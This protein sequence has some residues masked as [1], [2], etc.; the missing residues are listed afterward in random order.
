MKDFFKGKF[1]TGLIV[2]ATVILAGVAI[3]TAVR[4]YQLRR[5]NISLTGPESEPAAWD[6]KKYSFSVSGNGLVTVANNSGKNEAAQQAQVYI[7]DSLAATFDVPALPPGQGATLG[8]VQIPQ[9]PTF[10]WRVHGTK[11]C[12][13]SGETGSKPVACT[14]LKFNLAT[15]TT[16][17]SPTP[18][19]QPSP[20]PTQPPL[21]GTSP[22]PTFSQSGPPECLAEKP[23]APTITSVIKN[24]TSA[25]IT[26]TK[27]T[28]ATHYTISYGTQQGQY[29]YGV[30]NTGNV[31]SY[32]IQNLNAS[33]TYYFVVYAVNDCMPS[34]ASS[35]VSTV[36]GTGTGG[37]LPEAGIPTPTLFGL[38][39]GLLL[40][41]GAL[42]L[43]L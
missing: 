18:N 15:I 29:P 41:V 25:T 9:G 10:R 4:L 30:P 37:A 19:D 27:V 11:D 22:T 39:L 14:Q 5:E 17:V 35:V 40:I 43:A 6:C 2:A 32:T 12:Q 26:W 24:G 33:S 13:N 7:N 23:N 21:G 20:T 36:A 42:L 31:A 38:S 8:T 1:V 3:F 16:T 28:N 34:N